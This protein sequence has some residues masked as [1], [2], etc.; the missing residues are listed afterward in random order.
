MRG[1]AKRRQRR[2]AGVTQESGHLPCAEIPWDQRA[3][4][5]P[6]VFYSPALCFQLMPERSRFITLAHVFTKS[7]TNFSCPSDE[8]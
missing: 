8:A 7:R 1:S 6:R 3:A 5:G 2:S 4:R